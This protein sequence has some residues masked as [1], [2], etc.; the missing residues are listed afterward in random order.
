M[1]TFSRLAA[2]STLAVS[3]VSGVAMAAPIAFPPPA[4]GLVTLQYGDF[5]VY[6]LGLLNY[7]STGN[8]GVPSGND[9]YHLPTGPSRLGD[10]IVVAT[11]APGASNV[12][13]ANTDNPFNTAQPGSPSSFWTGSAPEPTP[14]FTGDNNG[15]W[16]VSVDALRGYLRGQS[17]FFGFNL[18]EADEGS[19]L[20]G[21]PQD[22]LAWGQVTLVD[23]DSGLDPV[24]FVFDGTNPV[25]FIE[26]QTLFDAGDGVAWGHIH[27]QICVRDIT[28]GAPQFLHVGAC[29]PADVG[30][31]TIRQNL[32]TDSAAFALT[33][34]ELNSLVQSSGY[35]IL[36]FDFRLSDL[37]NGY[38]QLFIFGA[39]PGSGTPVPEPA[40]IG[41]LGLGILGIAAARRR[42][43]AA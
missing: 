37:N 2:V 35:D 1:K 4:N 19:S 16:D 22:A 5:S 31:R 11:G 32:G 8:P 41:L 6:S 40:A 27:G 12:A 38:E 30:G 13:H 34:E 17:L 7:Y 10:Y 28:A 36:R 29:T 20:S 9:P 42:K 21:D 3:A 33:N 24:S 39:G 18:N 14:T 23:L 26:Q 25:P 43:Q 15:T